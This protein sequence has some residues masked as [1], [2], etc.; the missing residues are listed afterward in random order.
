MLKCG[1]LGEKLGHSYS[2]QIHAKLG[3]YEYKL[4]EKS[5]EEVAD[6]LKNGDF[7]GLNVTIPYKKT[8]ASLCGDL[9]PEARLLGS[10]NTIVRRPDGSLYGDNTDYYGFRELLRENA[11]EPADK[12]CLVLGSGGASVTVCAVLKDLGAEEVVVISRS[13]PD[14][15]GN[16]EKHADASILVNTTPVG[17]YP[18]N[19]QSP[20]Q[21]SVFNSLDAVI[22]VIYNPAHTELLLQA[23]KYGIPC[24]NGLYMLVSQAKRSSEIF[25]GSVLDDELQD[26]ITDRLTADMQNIV[27]IGMPGCGKTTVGTIL[28]DMTG[29]EFFDVDDEV[30][31]RAGKT[32]PEIFE[33]DGEDAFRQLEHQ[34]VEDFGKLSGKV[35][36]TG[37]GVIKRESNYAP[38]HQ[39]GQIFW[40]KRRLEDLPKDGRPLSLTTSLEEMYAKR[41]P[42]YE[43]FS[44]YVVY[45]YKAPEESA[46]AIVDMLN[47][48]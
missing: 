8:A 15:Y 34:V 17:M 41:E 38:L 7:D 47:P 30:A 2:P 13:G 21:L 45:N 32:I 27:L 19:G 48:Y 10:V 5:P 14:N 24:A 22:D 28:S 6:F 33:Q 11:I 40:I 9:S 39:N 43:A 25:T 37:G 4:Y 12:K 26:D 35:I 29:R 31:R 42:L 3:D 1:L 16:L 44:D 23:E 36:A 18:N 20:L 46:Q